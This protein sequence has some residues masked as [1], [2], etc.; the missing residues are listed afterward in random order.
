M[1]P[2]V[3]SRTRKDGDHYYH[4]YYSRGIIFHCRALTLFLVIEKLK[5][6]LNA[7]GAESWQIALCFCLQGLL[8]V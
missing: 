7:L 2:V 1:Q 4:F 5:L 3:Y 6:S 8:S